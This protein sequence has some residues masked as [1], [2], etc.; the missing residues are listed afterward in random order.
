M[1]PPRPTP[2]QVVKSRPEL[3]ELNKRAI[4]AGIEAANAAG[5]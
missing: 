4:N 5:R 2:P 3:I 1:C